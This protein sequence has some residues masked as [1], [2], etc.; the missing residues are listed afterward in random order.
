V[1]GEEDWR[2]GLPLHGHIEDPVVSEAVVRDGNVPWEEI[3]HAEA[4]E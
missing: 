3:V 4:A 1:A 2:R